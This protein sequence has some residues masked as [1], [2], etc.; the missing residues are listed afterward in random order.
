MGGA[1]GTMTLTVL[2]G[3]DTGTSVALNAPAAVSSLMLSMKTAPEGRRK[4]S[5]SIVCR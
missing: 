4:R 3:A 5:V 2:S 1:P